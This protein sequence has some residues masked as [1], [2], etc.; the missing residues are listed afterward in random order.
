MIDVEAPPAP[1]TFEGGDG[2]A[3]GQRDIHGV[4]GADSADSEVQGCVMEALRNGRG[5]VTLGLRGEVE[6]ACEDGV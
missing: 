6:V 5:R 2:G 3:G 4:S 1:G